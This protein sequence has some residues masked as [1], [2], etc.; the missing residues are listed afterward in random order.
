VLR[1]RRLN[2][3]RMTRNRRAWHLELSDRAQHPLAMPSTPRFS[4]VGFSEFGQCLKVDGIGAKDRV[5]FSQREF[6]QP[7]A[8]VRGVITPG[9]RHLAPSRWRLPADGYLRLGSTGVW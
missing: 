3:S 9:R 6:S 5:A 4:R 1:R 7:V 2:L 8:D